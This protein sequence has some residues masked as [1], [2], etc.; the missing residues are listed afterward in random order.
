MKRSDTSAGEKKTS[1]EWKTDLR[2]SWCLRVTY[3][4]NTFLWQQQQL[5]FFSRFSLR[6]LLIS[7]RW[8]VEEDHPADREENRMKEEDWEC[9][10]LN[11]WD[12][13]DVENTKNIS[14]PDLIRND[15]HF[16]VQISPLFCPIIFFHFPSPS[17][18]TERSEE[19]KNDDFLTEM[20]GI[21]IVIV[22]TKIENPS[23][24]IWSWVKFQ[25]RFPHKWNVNCAFSFYPFFIWRL[26]TAKAYQTNS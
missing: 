11:S 15:S 12:V 26:L 7:R 16:L 4:R 18:S 20:I 17:S 24:W 5:L 8:V 13:W 9:C 22:K 14:L 19:S 3:F 6:F 2:V 21:E 23:V 10:C 25:D 1:L